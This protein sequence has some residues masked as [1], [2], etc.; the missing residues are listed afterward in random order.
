MHCYCTLFD[1]NYL[2]RGLTLYC[3]LQLHEPGAK[4]VMLCLDSVTRDALATLSLAF[5]ELIPLEELERYDPALRKVR[6]GRLPAEYYFTCKAVLMR[7]V[8]LHDKGVDRVTYLDSDLF[9]FSDPTAL[10]T[11]FLG[12]TAIVTPHR[13]PAHLRDRERYGGFNAGWVSASTDG[14]GMR[15][16]EWWRERCLEWCKLI[17]VDE[18]FADQKYLNQVIANFPH[19]L[20]NPRLGVNAGPWN[21]GD[22]RIE[23]NGDQVL[24][25]GEPLIFFHFH[26][27]R[28]LYG[29]MFDSGLLEYRVSLTSELRKLIY[30]PYLGGLLTAEESLKRLPEQIRRDI[31]SQVAGKSLIDRL[32]HAKRALAILA[33][34]T[35][36]IG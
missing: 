19:A 33:S 24:I 22:T 10:A 29:K 11:E 35:A 21:I 15:F 31:G 23:K 1:R 36:M 6:D 26:G 32:R 14:E 9:C 13:F 18:K 12:A 17:V 27:F 25:D 8:A 34:R 20:A 3:S 5:V 4:V 30:E 7:Y 16:I 28:R 2:S